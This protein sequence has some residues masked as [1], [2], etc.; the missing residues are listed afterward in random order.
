MILFVKTPTYTVIIFT[1]EGIDECDI[2]PTTMHIEQRFWQIEVCKESKTILCSGNPVR[3]DAAD[4]KE[5][6]AYGNKLIVVVIIHVL[7]DL[8]CRAV[9]FIVSAIDNYYLIELDLL[10]ITHIKAFNFC[11]KYCIKLVFNKKIFY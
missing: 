6:R 4:C 3:P 5:V 7:S 10:S 8:T 2:G 9:E 11:E 1:F